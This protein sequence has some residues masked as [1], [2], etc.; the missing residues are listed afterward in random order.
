MD[1]DEKG[2]R[3]DCPAREV[4]TC[5]VAGSRQPVVI[6]VSSLDQ[7]EHQALCKGGL[8]IVTILVAETATEMAIPGGLQLSRRDLQLINSSSSNVLYTLHFSFFL[9]KKFHRPSRSVLHSVLP[10]PHR[11]RCQSHA[12]VTPRKKRSSGTVKTCANSRHL[13]AVELPGERS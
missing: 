13:D 9:F 5:T 8:V 11:R 7:T 10:S 3:T 4:R 2:G 1:I 12:V 6:S